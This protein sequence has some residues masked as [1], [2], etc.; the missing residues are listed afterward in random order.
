[1]EAWRVSAL[2][3]KLE[4]KQVNIFCD[5]SLFKL[6]A[7]YFFLLREIVSKVLS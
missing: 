1:M 6:P 7:D 4:K 3:Q 2:Q 5:V